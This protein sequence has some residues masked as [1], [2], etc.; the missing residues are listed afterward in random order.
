LK[1]FCCYN[2]KDFNR[3][4]QHQKKK[5]LDHHGKALEVNK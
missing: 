3:F 1:G 5:L 4:T 2:Q